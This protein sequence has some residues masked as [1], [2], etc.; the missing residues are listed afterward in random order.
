[1]K[2]DLQLFISHLERRWQS[3]MP[4]WNTKTLEINKS[5]LQDRNMDLEVQEI[6]LPKDLSYK[7]L[8]LLLLKALKEFT[9]AI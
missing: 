8:M 5:F 6:G 4:P 9:E 3:L 2:L 1:M 7:E